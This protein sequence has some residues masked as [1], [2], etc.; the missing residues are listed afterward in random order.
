MARRNNAARQREAR[1]NL[2]LERRLAILR[3]NAEQH[4]VARESLTHQRKEEI[5]RHDAEQRVVRENLSQQRRDKILQSDAE[6]YRVARENLTQER[7]DKILQQNAFALRLVIL[8]STSAST[9]QETSARRSMD[10]AGSQN[11]FHEAS[12]GNATDWNAGRNGS[13]VTNGGI[14]VTGHAKELC[15]NKL[16]HTMVTPP[17]GGCCT[18]L[19]YQVFRACLLKVGS[20][21]C[22][23]SKCSGHT[24]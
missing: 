3:N 16:G 7:R 22:W 18:L 11:P 12:N 14:D 1:A 19:L 23:V 8:A 2:T 24:S 4:R 5:L 15:V 20:V 21:M 9:E 10:A 13:A 6:Q 17:E